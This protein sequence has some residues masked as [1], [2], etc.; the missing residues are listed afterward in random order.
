MREIVEEELFSGY[1]STLLLVE[2]NLICEE[3]YGGLINGYY[4][5]RR[6]ECAIPAGE[7]SVLRSSRQK[8]GT[9]SN[10]GDDSALKF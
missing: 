5:N 8:Q 2:T 6:I 7:P 9:L 10:T 1:E 3:F 4:N